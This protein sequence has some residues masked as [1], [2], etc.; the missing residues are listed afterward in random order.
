M[1]VPWRRVAS[2]QCK[3]CGECCRIYKPKLT[4]Y[5]YLKLSSTGFVE[6][7]AGKFYIR[8]IGR[9]CP[10][11]RGRLCSLQNGKPFSCKIF[12]FVVRRK[13]E[14][15]ALFELEGE[16]FYVYADTFCPNLRIK[17]DLKPSREAYQLVKEAVGLYT[18]K[19]EFKLL[20]AHLPDQSALKLERLAHA[21]AV[22]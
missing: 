14:E 4:F 22:W 10:F 8:K 2:W 7:R 6:E 18:G 21:I 15:E 19:S 16:E 5:E 3:A 1:H 11:Q 12:P 13:G 17:T 20:T 9:R